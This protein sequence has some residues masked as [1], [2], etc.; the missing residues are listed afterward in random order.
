MSSM[1]REMESRVA[2]TNDA[3]ATELIEKEAGSFICTRIHA[4]LGVCAALSLSLSPSFPLGIPED[5]IT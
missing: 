1:H 2:L 5:V 4:V 3:G